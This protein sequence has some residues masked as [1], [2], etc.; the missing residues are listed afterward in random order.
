M[1]LRR[2]KWAN[3][4]I[5]DNLEIDFVNPKT[6]KPYSTIIFA[7]ENGT[8]KTTILETI[9]NFL[10]IGSFNPFD[11]IEYEVNDNVYRA[12]PLNNNNIDSFFK[13][14]D[15]ASGATTDIRSNKNNNLNNIKQD[16]KDPRH[17][18]CLLSKPRADYKTSIITSSTTQELDKNKYDDDNNDDFTS[19][20]QLLVD[21]Q[22]E[23][24]DHYRE[25]NQDR[26]RRVLLPMSEDE[27]EPSSK[28]HRFKKAFNTFFDK[29][30]YNKVSNSN[31][32]KLILFSKNGKDIALDKLSTGEKQ[33]VFRG[34]YLLKNLNQLSGSIIMVDE[35]ELSMHPKWQEKILGYYKNL[36]TDDAGSQFS[37]LLFASHSTGVISN[38]LQDLDD[39]KVFVLRT[40]NNGRIVSGNIEKPSVLPY[41]LAAE[42]N[43]QAFDI[44][45][46]DYHNAL[47]GYIEAEGWLPTFKTQYQLVNYNKLQ[48]DGI[49]ITS[50]NVSLS[51]KIRHIIHHPENCHNSYTLEQLK[52]SI[53]RMR[54]FIMTQP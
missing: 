23:D 2:V 44:A 40:D 5:L 22:G 31:G 30:K 3:H 47:Y 34:A 53:D 21:I 46:T 13:R 26:S 33:I 15:V 29:I 35:P 4:P 17:Y 19:L 18:G 27:F 51:E 11:F 6:N 37:Q 24:N 38:A 1:K 32:E 42:I 20:K 8:G 39:T 9:N 41:T 14:V 43:Y 12:V 28:M 16:D 36:F 54:N 45:S 25:I 10:C 52:E 50:C 49:T 48:K 7:G